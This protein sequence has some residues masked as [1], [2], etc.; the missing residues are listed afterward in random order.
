MFVA[1]SYDLSD[2]DKKRGMESLLR[3]YGFEKR[4]EG[5]WESF[6]MKER[7]L[8][9]LKRDIDRIT[10]SYD[11]IRLVQYPLDNDLVVTSLQN[12]RWKRTTVR[13]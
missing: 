2:D 9:R 1:I 6:K 5:F 8:S 12:K 11:S 7:Y 13:K 10:D 4:H 3:E